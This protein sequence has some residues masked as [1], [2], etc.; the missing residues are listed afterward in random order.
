ML[1]RVFVGVVIETA[2]I[3]ILLRTSKHERK[4]HH[5]HIAADFFYLGDETAT[6]HPELLL[7]EEGRGERLELGVALVALYLIDDPVELGLDG[8]LS[9]LLAAR[10]GGIDVD[11]HG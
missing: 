11:G 5:H 8:V 9:C 2:S 3:L 7:Y 6:I 10:F 4:K 1:L